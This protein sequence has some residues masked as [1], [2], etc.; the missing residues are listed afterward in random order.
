MVYIRAKVVKPGGYVGRPGTVVV[1][2]VDY[3]GEVIEDGAYSTV[4]PECVMTA[5]DIKQVMKGK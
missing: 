4:Y 1:T 2:P 5:D 3:R